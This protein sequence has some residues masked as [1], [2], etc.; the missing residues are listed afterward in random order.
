VDFAHQNPVKIFK[1]GEAEIYMAARDTSI[2][3]LIPGNSKSY[4]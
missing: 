1:L 3:Q 2:K 4:N